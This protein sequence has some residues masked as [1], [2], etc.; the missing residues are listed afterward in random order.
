MRK[1]TEEALKLSAAELEVVNKELETFSYSV[2]HDLRSPLRTLEGFSE[3]LIQEYGDKL[4]ETGQDYLNRIRKASQTMSQLIDDI[5]KLSRITRA[6]V[7]KETI[8]LN[9]IVEPI[10]AELRLTQPDR[11]AEFIVVP[12]INVNGDRPLLQILLRNLMENSWKYTSKCPQTRIEVGANRQNGKMVYFI[13]DNGIGFDM[14]QAD[15]LFQ[16][17]QRLHTS[18]DYPGTGIGLATA[19][20]VIHR[21]GGKIWAESEMGKGSTFY[22]T[23]D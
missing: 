14:K 23:L 21:H 2:S 18:K 9:A 15:K 22:F 16:P 6:E 20:R 11:K 8:D 12:E 7:H 13:K 19:Q 1:K 3:M 5:L 17:F 10:A 4:S